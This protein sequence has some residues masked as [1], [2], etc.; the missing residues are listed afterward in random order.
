MKSLDSM[1][2]HDRVVYEYLRSLDC[3][4]ALAVYLL[5]ESSE[6]D[7]L[8]ALSF[9]PLHYNSAASA[10][11]SLA[12]TKFLSKAKFLSTSFDVRKV[13][14]DKFYL[15]EAACKETNLRF[16]RDTFQLSITRDVLMCASRKISDIL[17]EF[18]CEE[19]VDSCDWGPGSTTSLSRRLATHPK[20][21]IASRDISH[22]AYIFCKDWFDIAFPSWGMPYFSIQDSAKIITVPK[23]AKTD[24]VIAVEPDLNIFFQKG[25]GKMI[26]RRLR[27][28]G[29][30][31]LN[32]QLVNQDRARE[33]SIF[34]N[35]ATVDFSAASDTISRE[36]VEALL[37]RDWFQILNS[38]RSSHGVLDGN[39]IFFEKFSSM[40]NGFTFE[41][42]S[43]IFWALADALCTVRGVSK[44]GL[45]VFGDDVILPSCLVDLY[46]SVCADCGFTVNAE[47]SYSS[48]PF[49]ESCGSYYWNGMSIKPIFLVEE[50]SNVEENTKLANKVRSQ[51]HNYT[52]RI[53]CDSRFRR[54]WQLLADSVG[55]KTPRISY[56][57]GDCGLIVNFN[58][59]FVT[60]KSAW[61]LEGFFTFANIDTPDAQEIAHQGL[62]LFRLK[63][64]GVNDLEQGNKVSLPLRTKRSRKRILVP[65][66]PDIGKWL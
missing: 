34:D 29:R 56:G 64:I 13:A 14:I 12:A 27:S 10:R 35:L 53:G 22:S 36:V 20:K 60:V 63:Q 16:R 38:L 19:F 15:A 55:V 6:H 62:L 65:Q 66:C 1:S 59:P 58:E 23:N 2:H 11:D 3:P 51:A 41:L 37:P 52:N 49:R 4:R 54:C 40:G 28:R 39:A 61:P 33:G 46:T 25:I 8:V 26:R 9:D 32:S 47:K 57:F 48:S 42:E 21:Y 45:S 7:Q 24:R 5:Y 18:Y 43:L 17:G 44:H 30:I 50:L 31:D